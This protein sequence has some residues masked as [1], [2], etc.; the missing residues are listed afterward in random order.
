MGEG[1]GFESWA[2]GHWSQLLGL[3]RVITGDPAT[4]EDVLQDALVDIYTRWNRIEGFDNLVGYAVTVMGSK[5]ANRRRSAWARKV[6]VTNEVGLIDRPTAGGESGSDDFLDV[7][8][9]LQD[10]NERQREIVAMHYLLDMPVADI[11]EML[12]RPIGSIT[13]DLTRARKSLRDI[14][15]R[16]TEAS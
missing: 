4:A 3:A 13:S 5:V 14:L 10:L 9:A 1:S 11:A 2:S 15:Q 7:T 8:R 12:N 16:G 6:A